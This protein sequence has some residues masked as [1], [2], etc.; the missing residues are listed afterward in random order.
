MRLINIQLG[1][2]GYV[3]SF[4]DRYHFHCKVEKSVLSNEVNKY[5]RKRIYTLV[6]AGA[7]FILRVYSR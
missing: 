3:K 5:F 6:N 7:K 4:L 2:I 1:P